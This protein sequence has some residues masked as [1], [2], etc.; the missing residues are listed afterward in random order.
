MAK[1]RPTKY[2][3]EYA[4]QAYKYCLLGADDV[5][6]A[7]LFEVSEATIYNWKRDHKEFLEAINDGK[8]RAD[9]EIAQAL[10]HRAKGFSHPEQKVFNNQGEI[11]VHDTVKHYPP[12]TGAAFIW[13]KNRQGA[14]W[15]DRQEVVNKNVDITG[16]S[17]E[18]LERHLA[19]LERELEK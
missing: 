14:Y 16:M 6:L 19:L 15:K 12:D 2:K 5:K 3:K 1:G 9:A 17:E 8:Y 18:E 4:E 13:L 11:I 7:S 10:Y